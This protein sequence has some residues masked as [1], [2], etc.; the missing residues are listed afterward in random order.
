METIEEMEAVDFEA[1]YEA[2]TI[3]DPPTGALDEA[4]IPDPIQLDTDEGVNK[5]MR[6][7]RY[8]RRRQ[9]AFKTQCQAEIGR[10]QHLMNDELDRLERRIAWHEQGLRSFL[11]A[12][13][14]KTIKTVYGK[15][16]RIA[17]R[18]KVEVG[19]FGAFKAWTENSDNRD[20]VR[21]K[22][23]PDKTAIAKHIK[24]TGEIPEGVDLVKGDDSFKVE[25]EG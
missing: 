4:T 24:A 18:E 8:F 6:A 11:W 21:V 2:A 16:K 17:G 25:T 10:I 1:E 13:G 20:L 3:L 14:E 9:D 7:V 5:S 12:S 15:L 23:E 22:E 19:D